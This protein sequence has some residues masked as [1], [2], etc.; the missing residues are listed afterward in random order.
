MSRFR[1]KLKFL[2][3]DLKVWNRDVFG[4]LVANNKCILKEIEILDN[5]ENEHNLE[6]NVREKRMDLLSQLRVFNKNL[7]SLSRQKARS[8]WFK[9]GDSNSNFFHSAIRWR[10]IKN[11]VKGVEVGNLWCEESEVVCG[12]AKKL[13]ED[14]F[15]ATH[16]FGVRLVAVEFK[17]LLEEVRLNMITNFTEEEVKEPVWLC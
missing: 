7:D 13:F 2:K 16:D 17:V 9:D 3:V 12:E 8:K 15:T 11:A 1:D 6:V 4:C 14:K 10:G 5:Q